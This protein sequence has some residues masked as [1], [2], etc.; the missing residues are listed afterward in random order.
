MSYISPEGEYRKGKSMG[1]EKREGEGELTSATVFFSSTYCSSFDWISCILEDKA[2][3]TASAMELS[4]LH[5]ASMSCDSK[6]YRRTLRKNVSNNI[7]G[8]HLSTTS[9]QSFQM[10]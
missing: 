3:S 10:K 1:K 9:K 2:F 8:P 7:A 4:F 6:F 5:F